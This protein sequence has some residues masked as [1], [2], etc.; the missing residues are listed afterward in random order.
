[1]SK[2]LFVNPNKWGRGI[3]AIWIPSHTALLIN[4]GHV[5]KLFD[6]TFYL[7]WTEN[8]TKF[9]TNNM[10]YKVT[11]YEQVIK[12]KDND[13]YHD[14]QKTIDEFNPDIIF[15]SAISS[16]I[17]GEG[18]Y[19][20]IQYFDQLIAGVNTNA[21]IL[22]GGLQP[23]AKPEIMFDKFTN[24]G[25]FICGESEFVLLQIADNLRTG[26]NYFD[27]PGVISLDKGEVKL[28]Q[29]QEILKD[30][31]KIGY[32]DYS[33]F[34]EQVFIRPYNGKLVKAVD[35]ELS[36]GCIYACD[37]CVETIIQK[38]YGF[39]EISSKGVLKNSRSYIRSKSANHI[40]EELLKLNKE[41]GI[42]LI[43]CQDTNF[44][45]INKNVLLELAEIM[46]ESDLDIMLYI[47]TRPEG[48]N[49]R[50]IKLLK[51][52]KVDGIGMGIELASQN[53]REEKLN[54]FADQKRIIKAFELLKKN[55]IKRTA[56]NIIGLPE[57]EE[58][59]IIETINFNSELDPDNITVAFYSPYIGT[60]QEIKAKNL[61]YFNDYENSIDGQLRTLN[62]SKTVPS[63]LL[64]FYKKYFVY[65][66]RNGLDELDKMKD[67]YS[68]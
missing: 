65:F 64:E 11:D 17:H 39:E 59:D 43:R 2:I 3:T 22:T 52:L 42:K 55:D 53:F 46:N 35:Y 15:G 60:S 12:Y 7:N 56:Y 20:N 34:D 48:I 18:E 1:M 44:L 14:L 26:K 10:Q 6:S 28:N 24:I 63:E 27:I 8:E 31:D 9:N 23:T 54:R 66:V 30:M 37:Y 21:I 62:R 49:E 4:N 25:L 13:I 16:H 51:K 38:Y 67:E 29:P 47:E 40:F 41:Y 45:T 33:L 36:R 5:V 50:T 68:I 58:D 57:E 61:S 19:V 32:Y